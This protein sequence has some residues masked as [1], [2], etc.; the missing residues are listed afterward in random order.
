LVGIEDHI[1]IA[2]VNEVVPAVELN[3][4]RLTREDITSTVHYLKFA[5]TPEQIRSFTDGPVRL[6][7][8]HPEYPVD[9]T[10]DEAQ[11]DELV[12]DFA[13]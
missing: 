9:V 11:R 13:A 12:G 2:V 4:D 5:F 3:A 1:K 7:V 6:L 10:L 8:D